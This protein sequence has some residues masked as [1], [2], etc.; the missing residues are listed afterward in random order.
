MSETESWSAWDF[1]FL[2]SLAFL[3]VGLKNFQPG[4]SID[5]TLYADVARNVAWHNM[6]FGLDRGAP[7]FSPF[8]EHPHLYV[9]LSGSFLKILPAEDWALR[10]PNHLV[11]LA[12]LF[13]GYQAFLRHHSRSA[14]L[15]FCLALLAMPTFANWHSNAYIDPLFLLLAATSLLAVAQGRG[16]L[17]GSLLALSAATKGLAVLGAVPA[18]V[19]FMLTLGRN[20][21]GLRIAVHALIG[22][23]I[24]L[25]LYVVPLW[26]SKTGHDFFHEYFRRQ[27]T[28][29]FQQSWSLSKLDNLEFWRLLALQSTGFVF[30]VP[31]LLIRAPRKALSWGIGI[32]TLTFVLMYGGAN[33]I[34][35]QYLLPF[36]LPAAIGCALIVAKPLSHRFAGFGNLKTLRV[37][38]I[39]FLFLI[40]LVQYLPI[41][42]HAR[43]P[44]PEFLALRDYFR[45]SACEDVE[46]RMHEDWMRVATIAWYAK[47]RL[48]MPPKA[49]D[50]QLRCVLGD[51]KAPPSDEERKSYG[52]YEKIGA[53]WVMSR[54]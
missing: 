40:A 29:R 11:Y 7:P 38:S 32:W 53:F 23:A 33:R 15:V 44:A 13:F 14:A 21:K 31:A 45:E 17:G 41:Q 18:F 10:I 34:G 37:L 36:Q 24:T 52:H 6:W 12:T 54:R 8:Y 3:A 9:W 50:T 5:G 42:V 28:S 1:I 49:G 4:L 2:L 20:K 48:V 47:I 19:F 46:L 25:L 26:L 39:A 22:F 27:F 35:S 51:L 30:F 43:H 16:G